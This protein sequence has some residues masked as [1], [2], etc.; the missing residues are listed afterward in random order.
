MERF[1][2]VVG[3]IAAVLL[4]VYGP[5]EFGEYQAAAGPSTANGRSLEP[6]GVKLITPRMEN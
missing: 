1:N 4:V 3:I 2:A 5:F 6:R